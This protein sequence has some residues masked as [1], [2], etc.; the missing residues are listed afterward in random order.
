VNNKQQWQNKCFP[1]NLLIGF[2]FISL[3]VV[4]TKTISRLKTS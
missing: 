1:K 2:I 4:T 3:Q